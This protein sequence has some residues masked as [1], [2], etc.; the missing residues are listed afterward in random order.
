MCKISAILPAYNVEKYLEECVNSILSQNVECE[1]IIIN[2][3]STDNTLS[4][5]NS[6]AEKHKNIVVL[7]QENSGQSVARNRGIKIAKGEYLLLLDSDDY[8][9]ENTLENVY[10]LAK[11]NQLDYI[12]TGYKTFLNGS[13]KVVVQ[14]MPNGKDKNVVITA[15]EFV[16]QFVGNGYN[17]VMSTGLYKL[18]Y[19]KKYSIYYEEGIQYEDNTYAI[20]MY[21]SNLIAKVMQTD[22]YMV[23]VRLHENTTTSSKPKLKKITDILKNVELMNDYISSLPQ[24]IK[25]TAQKTVSSLV[26]TMTAVYFR[27]DKKDR[28]KANKLIPK[29][30]LKD[31][32]KNPYDSFQKKKIFAFTYFRPLL[33]LYNIT[34]R[35]IMQKIRA[36]RRQ[37]G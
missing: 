24:D 23:M 21:T 36:K 32:I 17:V 2:D 30:I 9:I 37:N 7:T 35:N 33:S 4:V 22:I 16:N 13:N 31:S 20:K 26:F 18:D 29:Q 6:L 19:V 15:T 1:I 14:S 25:L 11:Q 10:N 27:L 28:K 3:G 5:A 12:R 8:L 34:L